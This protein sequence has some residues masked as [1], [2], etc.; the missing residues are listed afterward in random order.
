[1]NEQYGLKPNWR[2][3][4][5]GIHPTLGESEIH[6][7]WLRLKLNPSQQET[8]FSLLSDIQKDKYHRR[9]STE[10]KQAYLAGRYYLLSLLGQY[11]AT[12][13]NEVLLSYSR[14]NKPYLSNEQHNIEFNFTDT[15]INN[16]KARSSHG[17]FAFCKNHPIGVD[18]E[19]L[20]RQTDFINISSKRF[21]QAEQDFVTNEYGE[22]DSRRCLAI[23][24]RKEAFGKAI[25]K[26]IN[27]KMNAVNL[28][29]PDSFELNFSSH[30]EDWRLRQ[31][32]L[33]DKLISCVTHQGHQALDIKAF[34]CA[35]HLP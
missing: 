15:N 21:S 8:A 20:D 5:E 23:W 2:Q 25:G 19:S 27:F 33:T 11:T 13:A 35:N 14:L 9:K 7:W 3:P 12:P 29:S 4:D 16:D 10:L 28:A 22:T 1:M 24:T 31:I 32:Q 17:L 18:I 34:N 26:G 30:D 6:L